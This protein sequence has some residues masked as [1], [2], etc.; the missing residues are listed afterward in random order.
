LLK[1][2]QLP[3]AIAEGFGL[4]NKICLSPADGAALRSMGTT[5]NFVKIKE[6]VFTFGEEA[7]V[8]PGQCAFN[9][10]QR[11]FLGFGTGANE[12]PCEVF[13]FSEKPESH[14]LSKLVLEVDYMT[15]TQRAETDVKMEDISKVLIREFAGQFFSIGQRFVADI[16]AKKLLFRVKS[17]DIM[18]AIA[19]KAGTTTVKQAERGV[20][21]DK[22]TIN[23]E[24]A[25]GGT[26]RLVG[27]DGSAANA[28][29][30]PDFNF[31]DLGVGGLDLEFGDIFRRAFAS[32]IFPPSVV[33]KLGI[34]HV[35]GILL[36]GP[37][38]TG[39]TLMARQ[40]GK[41]LNGKEPKIVHGPEILDKFVGGSEQNVRNLFL[42]AEKEYKERKENSELHIIIFDEIDAICKQRGS[43]ND[44]TGVGDTVVNQLLTKIDGVE[45]LNN[46]LIIGMTNRKD[47]IDEALLRPG[48]LEVHMEISLPDEKGRVQILNIHTRK[49]KENG[50]MDPDVSIEQLAKDTKNF[51]GAEIEG[52]VKSASSFALNRK[53]D[54]T[55][56]ATCSFSPHA[57]APHILHNFFQNGQRAS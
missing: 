1:P 36:F 53:V 20:L 49:M 52:L 13:A 48:R 28:L 47:L 46:I 56:G 26:I 14:I 7:E 33:A 4:T 22:T 42:D 11:D 29:F 17:C 57:T 51:S 24:K 12:P 23:Y 16:A 10:V 31:G 32:R 35:K 27:D 18:D 39:K 44:G 38:G 3:A 50:F 5:P 19:L 37:P 41:M 30:K 40:I 43:R 15:K 25:A 6:F 54:A 9:R 8:K 21:F 55:N 34:H 45:S 2:T